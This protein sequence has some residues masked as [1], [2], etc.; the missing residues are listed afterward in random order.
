MSAN[1]SKI[2]EYLGYKFNNLTFL[3]TALTH[4]SYS[5]EKNLD[6]CN[7]RMEFL[8]DSILS[9][10]VSEYLYRKYFDD[11][12]GKLSQIKSQM[13]SA[14]NLSIWAKKVKLDDFV[15][16]S[17]S[18]EANG[19]R[20]RET[21]LCDSFEA[22]IGAV[23]LDS[24][25]LTVKSFIEKFIKEQ[26][27]IAFTDYKSYFQ[28]LIQAKHQS[29][30]EYR[31][32]GEHGPDHEKTFEVEVYVKEKYYGYGLGNSKKQAEQKAAESAVRKLQSSL[33]G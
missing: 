13:V 25:F 7:E 28:E 16:V 30:P 33:E 27:E 12:E 26:K 29:L 6:Y 23:Y 24:D 4:R 20:E 5:A 9:A 10:V 19:A 18:E 14:K 11:N 31:I 1:L 15:L 8:G 32:V 2:Q 22:V 21:L 17:F 3:Q